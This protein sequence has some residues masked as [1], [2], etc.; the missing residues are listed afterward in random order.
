MGTGKTTEEG[1]VPCGEGNLSERSKFPFIKIGVCRS[2]SHKRPHI[3]VKF[4][5]ARLHRTVANINLFRSQLSLFL[6]VVCVCECEHMHVLYEP[7]P[8]QLNVK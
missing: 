8:R 2:M 5:I 3:H 7:F 6:I 4:C 1:A